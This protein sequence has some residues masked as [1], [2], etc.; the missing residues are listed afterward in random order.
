[1]GDMGDNHWSQVDDFKWLKTEPSPNWSVL[2]E[3][4][5]LTEE[6]LL[7]TT[8]G[9]PTLSTGDVLRRFGI[10]ES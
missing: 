9:N 4:Q 10:K 2:S 6:T 5:R 1:M 7:K 3:E 8:S